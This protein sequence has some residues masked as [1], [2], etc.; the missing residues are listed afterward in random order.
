MI[1]DSNTFLFKDNR[2][3]VYGKAYIKDVSTGVWKEYD[4]ESSDIWNTK[5][6]TGR[7]FDSET[8]LY[9]Y[10]A[11]YYSPDLGRFISR[12]PIGIADNINLYAYVGNNPIEYTDPSGMY[13]M[14]E[15]KSD[16]SD[17][18]DISI[19]DPRINW[20]FKL[21]GWA[22]Q[23]LGWVA[24]AIAWGAACATVAGCPVGVVWMAYWST[25]VVWGGGM[26][27][28]GIVQLWTWEK[29]DS[30]ERFANQFDYLDKW[31]TALELPCSAK[32]V[33]KIG[34]EILLTKK[35]NRIIQE[36]QI[37]KGAVN[38]KLKYMPEWTAEQRL[39]ADG[40]CKALTNAE[41]Y[42]SENIKRL[43]SSTKNF[44][45][46]NSIPSSLDIDHVIDLQLGWK[47]I[48]SNMKGLDPSVNRSLGSQ[49]YHQIK[50][51]APWT[52]IGRVMISD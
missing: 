8:W 2:Y 12:D 14:S 27:W 26:M 41:T 18:Y 29:T 9:Y 17:A 28:D 39:C 45:V 6:F 13:S 48:F 46:Q 49:I 40:K 31:L 3:D 36:T 10:R 52:K 50:N 15:F 1:F 34:F 21:F 47:D 20:S 5:L 4:P 33:V 11:R 22:L 7:E 38:L 37:A 51:L 35:L 30:G 16:A 43:N 42:V 32:M 44:R 19:S 24:T 25:Q 23:W